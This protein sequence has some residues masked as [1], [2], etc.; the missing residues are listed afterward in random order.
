MR[1]STSCFRSFH[2]DPS[3]KANEVI[4]NVESIFLSLSF[5]SFGS[6]RAPPLSV[7]KAGRKIYFIEM[8]WASWL[9]LQKLKENAP[10][11]KLDVDKTKVTL[12]PCVSWLT[13][14]HK[15]FRVFKAV[16]FWNAWMSEIVS[17]Q[18]YC[19]PKQRL[20]H[21]A[22]SGS[23]SLSGNHDTRIFRAKWRCWALLPAQ[24]C[25]RTS[26]CLFFAVSCLCW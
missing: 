6:F 23:C 17:H 5:I 18:K 20:I 15:I 2:S 8:A 3:T 25:I 4:R 1:K 21:T 11:V 16:N 7:C 9:R 24:R 10:G 26:L 13:Q 19:S 14:T 22:Q 12:P